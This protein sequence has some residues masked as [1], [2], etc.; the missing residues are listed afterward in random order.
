ML[1]IFVEYQANL[2]VVLANIRNTFVELQAKFFHLVDLTLEL[3]EY[4][5]QVFSAAEPMS[6]VCEL[7]L[8]FALF[9]CDHFLAGLLG[10]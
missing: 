1:S 3:L 6:P 7:F 10:E 2:L 9:L 5:S 4:P 8:F